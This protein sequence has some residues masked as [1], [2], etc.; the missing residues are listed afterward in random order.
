[1]DLLPEFPVLC[2]PGTVFSSATSD[3]PICLCWTRSPKQISSYCTGSLDRAPSASVCA[4]LLSSAGALR[5][6]PAEDAEEAGKVWWCQ[7]CQEGGS[8]DWG[9]ILTA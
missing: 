9:T 7:S 1:M 8:E 5:A 2:F 3:I 4:G 6:L